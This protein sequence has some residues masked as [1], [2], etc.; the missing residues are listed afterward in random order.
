MISK[1][2]LTDLPCLLAVMLELT[3]LYYYNAP[4][5]RVPGSFLL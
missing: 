1:E 5:V 3:S 2:L 4:V